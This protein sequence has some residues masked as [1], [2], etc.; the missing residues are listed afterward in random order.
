V[1]PVRESN[2]TTVDLHTALAVLASGGAPV[3]SA[4]VLVIMLVRA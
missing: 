1:V 4:E 3:V 2:H